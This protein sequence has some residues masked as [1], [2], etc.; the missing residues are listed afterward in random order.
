MWNLQAEIARDIQR[1]RL[2]AAARH[3]L[4]KQAR[5]ERRAQRRRVDRLVPRPRSVTVWER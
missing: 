2:E 5:A 4:V 1:E 3:R